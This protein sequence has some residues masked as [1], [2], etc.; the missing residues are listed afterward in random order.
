MNKQSFKNDA[1]VVG[2]WD[3]GQGGGAMIWVDHLTG[4]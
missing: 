1:T 2:S 4:H 3:G